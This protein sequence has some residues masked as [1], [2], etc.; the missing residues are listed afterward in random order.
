MPFW[1]H[2]TQAESGLRA[3]HGLPY[4]AGQSHS[5]PPHLSLRCYEPNA[6]KW[7]ASTYA[8]R[9]QEVDRLLRGLSLS[10]ST[11]WS[12]SRSRSG[13]RLIPQ[14]AGSLYRGKRTTE[15]VDA[16]AAS[17]HEDWLDS[18]D[19][20][21]LDEILAYN[22]DDCL[23]TAQLRDWLEA[24]DWR[25]SRS[26]AR[27]PSWARQ[28]RASENLRDID[29]RTAVVSDKLLAGVPDGRRKAVSRAAGALPPWAQPNWHGEKQ[30][31]NGGST[32][33]KGTLTDE[34]ADGGSRVVGGLEF[35]RR[36]LQEK[37]SNIFRYYFDRPR[38]TSR[39][40]DS[41]TTRGA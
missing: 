19:Q 41:R 7:L 36:V 15:I 34:K 26:M 4:R 3:G 28:G 37:Q 29:Q 39:D 9:E 6:L 22:A 31:P 23:S 13:P 25:R 32:T 21:K 10:T 24:R 18:H 40:S 1:A 27:F 38:S 5:R 30:S 12:G 14:G 11:A 16:A 33:A 20:T 2:D 35:R 8:T 17:F